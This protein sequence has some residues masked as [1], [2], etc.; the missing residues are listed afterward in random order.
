MLAVN[1]DELGRLFLMKCL[2]LNDS[3]VVILYFVNVSGCELVNVHFS[4]QRSRFVLFLSSAMC[5]GSAR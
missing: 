5:K 3:I 2:N 4:V 1:D